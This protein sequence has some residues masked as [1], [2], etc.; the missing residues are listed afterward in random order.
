MERLYTIKP[1]KDWIYIVAQEV[2]K[3]KYGYKGEVIWYTDRNPKIQRISSIHLEDN[4][5]FRTLFTIQY[6][7]NDEQELDYNLNLKSKETK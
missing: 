7:Y 1:K 5:R 2:T 3:T 6:Q 4:E